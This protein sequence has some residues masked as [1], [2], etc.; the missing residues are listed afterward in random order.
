MTEHDK[1]LL[2]FF[3]LVSAFCFL[4]AP[5]AV[6]I[7]YG[8]RRKRF[9]F[10]L[11]ASILPSIALAQSPSALTLK[12]DVKT[13]EVPRTVVV[14]DKIQQVEKLPV[15]VVA[16]AGATDYRWKIPA[17]VTVTDDESET[18]EITAAPRGSITVSVR[19]KSYSIVDGKLIVAVK[20]HQLTFSIGEVGPNPKPPGPDPQPTADKVWLIVVHETDMSNSSAGRLL[21]DLD[22][23]KSLEAKGHKFRFYDKD[24]AAVKAKGYDKY[25]TDAGGVPALLIMDATGTVLKSTKLPTDKAGVDAILKGVVK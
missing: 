23:W 25:V 17:G 12:G 19:M 13:V 7:F 9:A 24:N 1:A 18:L 14:L 3:A 2:L 5:F 22:Y 10:A 20:V 11:A 16:P 15:V 6:Y 21:G 4:A 8:S